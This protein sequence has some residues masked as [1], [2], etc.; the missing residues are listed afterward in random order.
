MFGDVENPELIYQQWLKE[1][2]I[3]VSGNANSQYDFDANI[4][5]SNN[6]GVV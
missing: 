6:G 2:E 3:E 1:Q 4:D 5:N